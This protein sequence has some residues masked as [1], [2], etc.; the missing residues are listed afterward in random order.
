MECYMYNY[1]SDF[2][3]FRSRFRKKIRYTIYKIFRITILLFEYRRAN[4]IKTYKHSVS[5]KYKSYTGK[6]KRV[7][8]HSLPKYLLFVKLIIC[9]YL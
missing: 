2:F 1:Y 5:H 7:I 4:D 3:I 8:V 9:F 6:A